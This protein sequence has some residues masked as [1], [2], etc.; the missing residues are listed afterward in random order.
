MGK[1]PL[2]TSASMRIGSRVATSSADP[3]F[4]VVILR[5]I[6]IPETDRWRFATI[7]KSPEN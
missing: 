7:E 1:V 6:N 4:L 2:E 5:R 3:E